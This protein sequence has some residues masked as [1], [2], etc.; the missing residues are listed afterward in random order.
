MLID[1]KKIAEEI[2]KEL[3]AKLAKSKKKLRL[4]IIQ[5]GDNEVTARFIKQKEKFAAEIGV[6][7]RSY[8]F[9]N[10]ISTTALRKKVSEICH[11]KRNSGVIIQLPL[12]SHINTQYILDGIP[13]EKD[14]DVLSAKAL[15]KFA[16]GKGVFPPV[17]GAIK[18]I[19]E[20][21]RVEIKGRNIAVIGAGKLVGAPVAAWLTTQGATV[22]VLNEY[23]SHPTHYTLYS[24]IIISGIGKPGFITADMVKNDVVIIDAG[25]SEQASKLVGDVD[26]TVAQKALLFTPVPGGIGP[27]TVAMIFK[28]LFLL[29]G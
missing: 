20:R 3:K 11:L 4:A 22:S 18:E 2:K 6:G 5:V 1:G 17:V 10:D 28:N 25:T 21:H 13:P 12:P 29:N 8:N 24:D 9:S 14:V 7:T 26:P 27:I 23:S 19:L 15:G 16:T